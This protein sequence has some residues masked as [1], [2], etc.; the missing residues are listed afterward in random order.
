M[1]VIEASGVIV[2]CCCM[3][4]HWLGGRLVAVI[5]LLAPY[6][7]IFLSA[8]TSGITHEYTCGHIAERNMLPIIHSSMHACGMLPDALHT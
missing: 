2:Y 1:I 3:A 7:G 4:E 8:D 6:I 5:R